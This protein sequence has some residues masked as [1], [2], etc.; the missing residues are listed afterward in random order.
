MFQ[1]LFFEEDT[2]PKTMMTEHTAPIHYYA[3]DKLFFIA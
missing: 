1:E 2:M 3:P